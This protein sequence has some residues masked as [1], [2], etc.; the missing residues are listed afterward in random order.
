MK[1]SNFL[2]ALSIITLVILLSCAK[3]NNFT[4]QNGN[5]QGNVI[6]LKTN[7]PINGAFIT[8]EPPTDAIV[9]DVNGNFNIP[10]YTEGVY[11]VNAN[12][13]GYIGN[14][15]SV[16]VV[17]NKTAVCVIRLSDSISIN[18]PPNKPTLLTPN[19]SAT[20][21][22]TSIDLYWT[23]TDPNGDIIYYNVYLDENPMPTTV[24]YNN[25][26]QEHVTYTKLEKG[27]KYYWKVQAKDKYEAISE[28]EIRSF[29]VDT[30]KVIV[31]S[32]PLILYMPFDNSVQLVSDYGL[33]CNATGVKFIND[34]NNLPNKAAYFDG[35]AIIT[36]PKKTCLDLTS[37]F[38]L[39]AWIK[40][41][42]V[43]WVRSNDYVDIFGKWNNVGAGNSAYTIQLYKTNNKVLT[44][45]CDAKAN[46][47]CYSANA[48]QSNKWTHIACTLKSNKLKL[49]INGILETS[50]NANN[51]QLSN[52]DLVIGM[53]NDGNN[54]FKGGMD[55]INIYNIALSDN[56]IANLAK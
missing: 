31:P 16:S 13:Q 15:E 14:H 1:T 22:N 55:E 19:N 51:C 25:I 56:E 46:F 9:S 44:A 3:E 38:T 33:S 47:I 36:I 8:T 6:D 52:Y 32:N 18:L 26:T 17:L 54:A 28:S 29:S 21:A 24:I 30:S 5:I 34:R 41:D 37:E 53:Q 39:S 43:Y 7:S 12:K 2:T 40:P 11:I 4:V 23:C 49:Y 10:V 27:K 50:I 45:T 35:N 20:F 42:S 48:I